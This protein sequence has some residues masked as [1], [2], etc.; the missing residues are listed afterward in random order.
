MT[1]IPFFLSKAVVTPT[2]DIFLPVKVPSYIKLD[3]HE[4]LP[5]FNMAF[6]HLYKLPI[7]KASSAPF[8][9]KD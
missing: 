2:P 5:S 1:S 4:G 6:L 3:P 7:F 8:L 9:I